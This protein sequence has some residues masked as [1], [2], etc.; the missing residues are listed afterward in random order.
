VHGASFTAPYTSFIRDRQCYNFPRKLKKERQAD[1]LGG[2]TMAFLSDHFRPD[3]ML[4]PERNVDDL[5]LATLAERAGLNRIVVK[6]SDNWLRAIATEQADSI[7]AQVLGDDTRE[8]R[9]MQALMVE[10]GRLPAAD[11]ATNATGGQG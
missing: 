2:G 8:I 3:P 1:I 4:F 9:Y 5:T 11:T 6:R 10:M 7:W